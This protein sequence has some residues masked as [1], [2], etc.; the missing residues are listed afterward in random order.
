[1]NETADDAPTEKGANV[2]A[3]TGGS[4]DAGAGSKMEE[5]KSAAVEKQEFK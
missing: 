2:G 4:G 5:L 3:G 1:M